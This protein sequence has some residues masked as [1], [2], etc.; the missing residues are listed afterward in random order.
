MRIAKRIVFIILCVWLG[1]LLAQIA[2]LLFGDTLY[3]ILNP[4]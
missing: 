2:Y 1:I 3:N 4:V